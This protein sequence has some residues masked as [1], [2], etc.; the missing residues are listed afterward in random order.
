MVSLNTSGWIAR[1]F[2]LIVTGPTD[3]G[4]TWIASASGNQTCRHGLLVLFLRMSLLF[5]ELQLGH[6][7]G[8]FRKRLAQLAKLDLLILD[9]F[10][11]APLNAQNRGDLLEEI[12]RADRKSVV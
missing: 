5:E 8:S 4:K 6:P 7:D 9:D 10:G 2:D 1:G 12:G 3:C 11:I